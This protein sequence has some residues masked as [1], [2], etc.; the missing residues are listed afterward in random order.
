M[1]RPPRGD[2]MQASA[3]LASF[4]FDAATRTERLPREPLPKPLPARTADTTAS[5]GR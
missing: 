4:V 3:V 2:L 1:T 5:A